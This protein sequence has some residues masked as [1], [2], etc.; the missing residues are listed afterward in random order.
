MSGV[1]LLFL[2]LMDMIQTII[3]DFG[4]GVAGRIQ[5][6]DYQQDQRIFLADQITIV[7][8]FLRRK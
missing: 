4:N 3:F 6:T 1:D 7:N 2:G 8:R 5:V